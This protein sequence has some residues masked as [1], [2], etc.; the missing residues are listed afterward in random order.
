MGHVLALG[1][2]PVGWDP[3]PTRHSPRNGVTGEGQQGGGWAA[4]GST[5]DSQRGMESAQV[6]QT[7]STW[8]TGN[9]PLSENTRDR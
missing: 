3:C 2:E 6:A 7:G 4:D 1:G 8:K 5:S 9:N